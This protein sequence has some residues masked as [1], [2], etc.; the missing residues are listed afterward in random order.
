MTNHTGQT[1]KLEETTCEKDLGV[2][3][4]NEL[5][6]KHHTASAS[7]KANSILGLIRRSF[8]HIDCSNMS[9]LYKTM[10]RPHL[11]YGNTVWWPTLKCQRSELEKVQQRATKLIPELKHLPYE[12][13]LT[14]PNMPTIAFRHLRGTMIDTYKY[15]THK[16]KCQ[17]LNFNT[18][19][20]TRSNGY[21]L[22]KNRCNKVNTRTS[23]QIVQSMHGTHYQQ[24]W[25]LLIQ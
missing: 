19:S 14:I 4:D 25:Y 17:P 18:T 13:R 7:K 3:I 21:K 23:T 20:V 16:Y 5:S 24:K 22:V 11:E 15:A 12:Q 8:K 1:V 10:V 2:W 9:Q 6:F